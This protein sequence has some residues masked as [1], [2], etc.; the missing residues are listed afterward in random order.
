LSRRTHRWGH[1][2]VEM[3]VVL[4]IMSFVL[5]GAY[6]IFREGIQLFKTNQAAADGQINTLKSLG[7]I[8][9]EV[10]VAKPSLVRI[11]PAGGPAGIVFAT[12]LT[13]DGV[14][15]FDPDSGEVYWQ[16]WVCFYFVPDSTGNYDGKIY[17]KEEIIPPENAFG[18]GSTDV[19]GVVSP[20]LASRDTVYF[21][22]SAGLPVRL[23]GEGI[24]NL[25]VSLYGGE[26]GGA[27][28]TERDTYNV[29]VEAGDPTAGQRN[30]YYIKVDSKVSPQG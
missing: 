2:L 27:G 29:V 19:D 1:S 5:L 12:S 24:S 16:K 14:T 9:S 20:G 22:D 21:R 15:R 6:E 7:R 28:S 26:I 30:G 3:I 8:T 4:G 23:L 13:D 10:S 25:D 17:R 18:P 11:Y